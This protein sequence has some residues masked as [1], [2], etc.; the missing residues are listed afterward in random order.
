MQHPFK[1][2]PDSPIPTSPRQK[3]GAHLLGY[4]QSPFSPIPHIWSSHVTHPLYFPTPTD[5]QRKKRETMNK[6]KKEKPGNFT[7]TQLIS[8]SQPACSSM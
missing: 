1:T 3:H 6:Q 5:F 4:W 7:Y 8:S 2:L